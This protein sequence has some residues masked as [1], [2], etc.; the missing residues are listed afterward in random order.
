MELLVPSH[1]PFSSIFPS[2]TSL[3]AKSRSK[4]LLSK[5]FLAGCQHIQSTHANGTGKEATFKL[6]LLWINYHHSWKHSNKL[7]G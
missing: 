7:I 4:R 2:S 3:K 1:G 6:H 5:S